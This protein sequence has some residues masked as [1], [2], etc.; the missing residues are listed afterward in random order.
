MAARGKRFSTCSE[1]AA[2]MAVFCALVAPTAMGQV[3]LLATAGA[4]PQAETRDELDQ[5][6]LVFDASD[7]RT[8]LDRA[9]RFAESYPTSDFLEAVGLTRMHAY[10]E[11]GRRADLVSAATDVLQLNPE[12]PLAL[13]SLAET[14]LSGPAN[15]ERN[16]ERAVRHTRRAVSVLDS[17][18]MPQGARSRDWLAA[19]KELL[20]RAHAMLGYVHLK[21]GE[22]EKAAFE[23]ELAASLEPAGEYFYR[24][25]VAYQFSGF[26]RKASEAFE[27]A[28]ELGPEDVRRSAEERLNELRDQEP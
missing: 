11:L 3:S 5:A 2:F 25:G 22:F 16:R 14:Y 12:N 27:R 9:E 26:A 8:I 7:A 28:I 21:E 23:L 24:A 1:A 20:A 13:V 10:R 6:G 18:A 4:G 19:K 17:L 15:S